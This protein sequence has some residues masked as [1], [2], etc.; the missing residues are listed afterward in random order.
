[1]QNPYQQASLTSVEQVRLW[2]ARGEGER[3]M[4]WAAGLGHKERARALLAYEREE[5]AL[6]RVCL[7][8][9]KPAEALTRLERVLEQTTAQQRWGQV[10]EA[11]LLQALAYQ[12]N[13]Q[14]QEALAALSEAVG[15]AEP[16]GYIRSF[17]DEGAP[18]EN[19]LSKLRA[20]ERKQGP[21]PYLDTVLASFS[22]SVFPRKEHHPELPA[23]PPGLRLTHEQPHALLDPLSAREQEVLHL[24]EQ[25]AS[26][27][28]IAEALV[29]TDAT[30]KYHVSNILSKLQVRNRTQAVARARSLGLLSAEP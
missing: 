7:V 1:V 10:L 9:K 4:H 26:N 19:L 27:Q 12:M 28:E 23:S 3:A 16:E 13:Q 24:L 5:V 11:R 2:V 14:E 25:G 8:Q 22:S 17:V 21:T 20:Q 30:I 18:M 29:V 6:V 15:L